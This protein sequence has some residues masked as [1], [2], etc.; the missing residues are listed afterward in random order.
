SAAEQ[1]LRIIPDKGLCPCF[2]CYQI[3][4]LVMPGLVPG[5]HVFVEAAG[6]RYGRV[7][8]HGSSPWAEGPR[9]KPGHDDQ[10]SISPEAQA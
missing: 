2:R 6:I 7:D 4:Y 3:L 1:R 10:M 8:A 9:V 5:I